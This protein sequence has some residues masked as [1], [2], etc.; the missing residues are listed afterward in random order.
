MALSKEEQEG[1]IEDI[2]NSF[3]S[4]FEQYGSKA[5]R[6]MLRQ[7]LVKSS[8][9]IGQAQTALEVAD[10]GLELLQGDLHVKELQNAQLAIQA[11]NEIRLELREVRKTVGK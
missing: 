10:K 9:F 11:I 2:C 8:T 4:T 6:I 5:G 1:E 3:I 7:F